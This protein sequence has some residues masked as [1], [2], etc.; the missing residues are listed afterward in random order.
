MFPGLLCFHVL[1]DAADGRLVTFWTNRDAYAAAQASFAAGLPAGAAPG[2]EGLQRDAKAPVPTFRQR[3]LTLPKLGIYVG[4]AVAILGYFKSFQ[5]GRALV[6]GEN[7]VAATAPPTPFD[8][9]TGKP[10]D[11]PFEARNVSTFASCNPDFASVSVEALDGSPKDGLQ[12]QP[13][14]GGRFVAV[15]PNGPLSFKV[16]GTA[17]RAGTYKVTVSGTSTSGLF[18]RS[19]PVALE[20]VVKIWRPYAIGSRRLR[21]ADDLSCEAEIELLV[22]QLPSALEIQAKLEGVPG[23]QFIGVRF[24]HDPS[25]EADHTGKEEDDAVAVISWKA[26]ALDP[27]RSY[28]F[29]LLLSSKAQQDWG[30]LLKQIEFKLAEVQ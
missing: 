14:V 26:R 6:V 29:V 5:E 19:S 4:V 20:R 2:W 23:V 24:P 30:T 9:L 21:S 28:T 13:P 22:G 15:S 18:Q 17:V 8:V 1:V 7:K 12:L 10:F 16:P 11:L 25:Y 27:M 3:Y